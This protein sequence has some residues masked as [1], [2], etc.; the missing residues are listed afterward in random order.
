[1]LNIFLPTL[2]ALPISSKF[3]CKLYKKAV[4]LNTVCCVHG[5]L[6]GGSQH[7]G[8]ILLQ[9]LIGSITEIAVQI[10]YILQYIHM[11]SVSRS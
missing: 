1:M 3:N 9:A 8:E 4:I 10:I 2:L 11:N 5:F 6:L 7:N